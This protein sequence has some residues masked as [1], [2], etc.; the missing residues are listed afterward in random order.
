MAAALAVASSTAIAADTDPWA[1]LPALLARIQP[2]VFP[3]RTFNITNY[4]AAPGGADCSRAIAAAIEKC[5]ASGGGHVVVPP[6]EFRCGPIRLL[7]GVD[8]H[9]DAGAV[10]LFSTDPKDYLPPVLTRFEGMECYNYSPLIYAFGERNIAV[11]GAGTLDGQADDA[12][13]WSWKGKKDSAPGVPNQKAARERLARMVADNVPPEQRRFGEGD[14]LRPTFIQPYRCS[15]VLVEG[16]RIRRSPMWEVSPVL[17]TNVIVRGLDIVSH[18]PNNDGCDPEACRDVLIENCLFDTGDD[19]IAIKSG[20]NNDGRRIGVPSENLVI[21]GCTMKDGHAGV[22]IGSE[23]SGGCR[24]V[25]VENCRMD[26]PH[27]DRALRLKS[28][29]VRGG[30]LEDIYMRH[31]E[32]GRVADAVLQIDF[33]YEEGAKGPYP[34][35]VRRVVVEDVTVEHTPRVFN[36]TGFEGAEISGVRVRN[37]T[38]HDVQKPDVVQHADA[39]LENC[40]VERAGAP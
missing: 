39:V 5:H 34:P 13:W 6:G 25:F 8:L 20:R 24:N 23:I 9:L 33:L 4:A 2:P 38:F 31:V 1:G 21:R 22:A 32:V 37:S 36:I 17:C 40:V 11:T 26:S 15:N 28:N 18:G 35:A 27:L 29:A 30:V 12:H 3:D 10:L 19:C 7:G 14:Y 16:V